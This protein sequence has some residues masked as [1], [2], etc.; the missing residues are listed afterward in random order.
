[1]HSC[2]AQVGNVATLAF[3]RANF[4]ALPRRS[5]HAHCPN[6]HICARAP[7]DPPSDAYITLGE[8]DQ[9]Q[10]CRLIT[11]LSPSSLHSHYSAPNSLQVT[12]AIDAL[13]EAGLQTFDLGCLHPRPL[14]EDIAFYAREYIRLVGPSLASNLR[15]CSQ[16]EIDPHTIGDI[17]Q[18][19]V[20]NIVDQHLK[21]SGL[22]RLDLMQL[23]WSDFRDKRYVDF[24]GE[25]LEL[26][27]IGKIASIGTIAFPTRELK[28]LSSQGITVASNQVSFSLVDRRA[29]VDMAD[30][31]HSNNVRLLAKSALGAGFIS[32]RFLGLPE[33]SKRLCEFP[34]V[35]HFASVIRAWGGWSLF[36]ELLYA[37]KQVADKHDVTMSNVAVKW[38]LQSSGQTAVV[39]DA[40]LADPPEVQLC[41]SNLR[42][43]HFTLDDDDRHLLD[44]VASK[45]NDLHSIL[46]DCGSELQPRCR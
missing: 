39:V 45:C 4:I 18:R 33:P 2:F 16:A 43:F 19:S 14:S 27:R 24:L 17:H 7:F 1:M 20:Q 11:A 46:G 23:S 29:L 34:P 10:V 8:H 36:Q 6:Q 28:Y 12:R 38:A 41:I 44:S 9:T 40:S 3:L 32:E 35:A 30:W 21:T 5:F 31:C 26:K 15:F 25:L 13:V 42:V 22:E 37:I